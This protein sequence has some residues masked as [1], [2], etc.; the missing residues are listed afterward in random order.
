MFDKLD[1]CQITYMECEC[2]QTR[3]TSEIVV[4]TNYHSEGCNISKHNSIFG[5][6]E[7]IIK[8]AM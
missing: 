4:F 1:R 7:E 5:G 8:G 6:G 2:S 3:R